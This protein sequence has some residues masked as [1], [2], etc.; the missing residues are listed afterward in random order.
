MW[1]PLSNPVLSTGTKGPAER[2]SP[3]AVLHPEPAYIAY[4][5]D[6]CPRQTPAC[7]PASLRDNGLMLYMAKLST[8]ELQGFKQLLV[9]KL[10]TSSSP[11]TGDQLSSAS[12]AE[13]VHLLVQ[14]FPGR[15]AWDVAHNIFSKMNQKK[16][17][18]RVQKELKGLLPT[19]GPEDERPGESQM[20]LDKEESDQ[21]RAY[22]LRVTEKYSPAWDGTTWPGSQADFL[23][24]AARRHQELLTCLFLPRKPECAP[25]K[26]VV[27]QGTPSI[28]KTTLA[29]QVMLAW[30]WDSFY[31][32]KAWHAFYFHCQE[33]T[34]VPEQSCLELIG[35]QLPGSPA[36]VSKILSNPELLFDGFEELTPT[37]LQEPEALSGDWKQQ[38]PSS[39]LLSSLLSKT[40][41]PQASLLVAVRPASWNT[42]SHLLSQT[43]MVTLTGFDRTET[44]EYF[45][46]YFGHKRELEQ[47]VSFALENETLLSR[48]RVPVVYLA[49]G[50]PGRM[51]P[52]PLEGLCHLAASGM[53]MEQWVFSKGD[54]VKAR[55][56]DSSV[57]AFLSA[58]IL[59]RVNGQSD[60]YV[61]VFFV[62]QELFA[63]F[64]YVLFFPQRLKNFQVLGSID[65]QSLLA[66]PVDV[67]HFL[68]N[69]GLFLFGLLNSDCASMMERAFQHR[70]TSV[71][72]GKVLK[73]L[74]EMY[75]Y[76][77]PIPGCGLQQLFHCLSEVGQE[78]FLSWALR[79]LC[80]ATLTLDSDQDAQASAFCLKHCRD[81]KR[82]ELTLSAAL[83]EALGPK[84]VDSLPLAATSEGLAGLEMTAVTMAPAFVWLLAAALKHP[85][86]LLRSLSLKGVGPSMLH[87]DLFRVFVENSHMTSLEIQ[88]TEVGYQAAQLL[89]A[90]L[91]SP[92][93]HIQSL[94]LVSCV[95][96]PREWVLLARDLQDS[97]H[98][99]T[100]ALSGAC[101]AL[102]AAIFVSARQL[103][104]LALGFALLPA[105]TVTRAHSRI[106]THTRVLWRAL[107]HRAAVL[108]LEL[109]IPPAS[110]SQR[111]GVTGVHP[112][113]RPPVRSS[114]RVS[115]PRLE[116]CGL[117]KLACPGVAVSL[118]SSRTLTHLSL[119]GN[120]LK[121][122]GARHIWESLASAALPLQR[123]V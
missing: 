51:A 46:T 107:L 6:Q 24:R 80:K 119:A 98:L 106:H 82:V 89:R 81:L 56:E 122:E 77:L 78:T 5:G 64:F 30:A 99:Q 66:G 88:C 123:L 20:T 79:G 36:L 35:H 25:P 93:C 102:S 76:H 113:T 43:S 32:H 4:L 120:A 85:E 21:I 116:S 104:R 16:M 59:R 62:F 40:M 29:K 50:L 97:A 7:S 39:A 52:G 72:R 55:V 117:M 68:T 45:R 60:C 109:T 34:Q 73:V 1:S 22:K 31:A 75:Q 96:P 114:P 14:Q 58:N 53:R 38:L 115:V 12:W 27:I 15:Q 11:V 26:A 49:K 103:R 90:T 10:M 37:L 71:N 105:L 118:G 44:I 84:P 112:H 42:V 70:V 74:A 48:C 94:R 54:L 57:A 8:G 18:V 28:G 19:W 69:M 33:V 108:Q 61:F 87:E 110:A 63:V 100:L 47:A 86:G 111:A 65:I 3:V 2:S 13:V 41:L 67:W 95:A 91:H 121:D 23:Y 9:E 101:L 83:Q 17:C 92:K